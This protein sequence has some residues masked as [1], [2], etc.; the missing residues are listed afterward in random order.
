MKS[1]HSA[2]EKFFNGNITMHFISFHRITSSTSD[3]KHDCSR[4]IKE[5][6]AIL[7][8]AIL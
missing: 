1:K 8:S 5:K 2:D 3:F 6:Y 7:S 4:N